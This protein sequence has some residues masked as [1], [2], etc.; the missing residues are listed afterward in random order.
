MI[1]E[2]RDEIECEGQHRILM[3]EILK[4]PGVINFHCSV[5]KEESYTYIESVWI[6]QAR[7]PRISPVILASILS[8]SNGTTEGNARTASFNAV[9]LASWFYPIQCVNPN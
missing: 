3:R 4:K 9:V 8:A 2:R 5:L 1:A 7:C 6:R